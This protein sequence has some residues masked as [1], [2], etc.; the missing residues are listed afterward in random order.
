[1]NTDP[2]AMKHALR[3]DLPNAGVEI[4]MIADDYPEVDAKA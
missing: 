3:G 2:A 4:D 1:V